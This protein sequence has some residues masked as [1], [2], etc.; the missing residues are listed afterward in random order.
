MSSGCAERQRT[1]IHYPV[2]STPVRRH[3]AEVVPA[4]PAPIQ[5]ISSRLVVRNYRLADA[6]AISHAINESRPSLARWVPDIARRQ[7]LA[8]VRVGLEL[9]AGQRECEQRL[10]FGLWERASGA[11][12][13]EVGLYQLDWDRR[14]AEIGYWLRQSARGRGYAAEGLEL[15]CT[16]ASGGLAL[17]QLEAH[18]APENVASRGVAERHGF[19]ITGQR[20]AVSEWD[21]DVVHVLIYTRELDRESS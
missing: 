5:M 4:G 8:E 9:L 13:G 17:R 6:Q 3:D 7:T 21:G 11:F 2:A 1:P 18:V 16:L 10:V 14:S 12:L 19:R 20:P 15:V